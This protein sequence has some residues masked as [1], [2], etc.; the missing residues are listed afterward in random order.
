VDEVDAKR[1]VAPHQDEVGAVPPSKDDEITIE[2]LRKDLHPNAIAFDNFKKWSV[3]SQ[4]L[5]A[6]GNRN[7]ALTLALLTGLRACAVEVYRLAR[8]KSDYERRQNTFRK[9]Q[10][11]YDAWCRR[12]QTGYPFR[13][14]Q[15]L[16]ILGYCLAHK[17]SGLSQPALRPLA[18][19]LLLVCRDDAGS[20]DE[21]L[22][23]QE[24]AAW[25]HTIR[26]RVSDIRRRS[27][28]TLEDS[29]DQRAR[30]AI[31]K[32]NI[33]LREERIRA[34]DRRAFEEFRKQHEHLRAKK[35]KIVRRKS[36]E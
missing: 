2:R 18:P 33:F 15:A 20:I 11:P 8:D 13:E 26:K 9:T 28:G 23:P 19:A 34:S 21:E 6:A 25:F 12:Q 16:L 17:S 4:T 7:E 24:F 35:P 5:K 1:G 36:K 27:F 32:V 31:T 22:L 3:V 30:S 10:D 14:L 29:V